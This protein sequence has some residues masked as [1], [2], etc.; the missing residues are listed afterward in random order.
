MDAKVSGSRVCS[1]SL[2]PWRLAPNYG[3]ERAQSHSVS[4]IKSEAP[5]WLNHC[6]T[7]YLQCRK[8]PANCQGSKWHYDV[9][10]NFVSNGIYYETRCS[11]THKQ[12]VWFP[13]KQRSRFWS[14]S[15]GFVKSFQRPGCVYAPLNQ[16]KRSALLYWALTFSHLGARIETANVAMLELWHTPQGEQKIKLLAIRETFVWIFI[17]SQKASSQYEIVWCLGFGEALQVWVGKGA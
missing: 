9:L 15:S 8:N 11:L 1:K 12:I 10:G 17:R 3:R 6:I 4:W 7:S 5:V 14:D 16:S 13:G 2:S